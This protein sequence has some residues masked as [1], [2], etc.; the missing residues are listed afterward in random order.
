MSKRN[1]ETWK[2]LGDSGHVLEVNGKIV[3][4]VWV[5]WD[6]MWRGATIADKSYFGPFYA[7]SDAREAV[8]TNIS[9]LRRKGGA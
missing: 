1:L 6:K 4:H 7:E 3:A 9:E 5:G 2:K 8:K